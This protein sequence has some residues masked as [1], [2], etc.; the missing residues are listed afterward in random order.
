MTTV[1]LE[2]IN[3][4]TTADIKLSPVS[5]S[6]NLA[7]DNN[8]EVKA[9]VKI[10]GCAENTII[11]NGITEI[12]LDDSEPLKRNNNYALKLYFADEN[13]DL[14]EIAKKYGTSVSAIIEEN[15]IEDDTVS[16]SGMILIPIV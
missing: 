5:C 8:V 16:G 13:E 7:S 6:Y 1:G 14:W 15:E 4:M 9:E 12:S 11:L 10:C 3:D 2:N